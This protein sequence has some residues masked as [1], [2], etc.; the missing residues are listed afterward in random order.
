[1]DFPKSVHTFYYTWYGNPDVDGFWYHWETTVEE[2]Y[3]PPDDITANFYPEFGVYSSNDPL[4]LEEHVRQIQAAGIDVLV[5]TWTG[6]GKFEDNA[7]DALL[8]ACEGK[9]EVAFHYEPQPDRTAAKV[10]DDLVYIHER[11]GA[12]PA[13]YK[14]EGRLFFYVYDSYTTAPEEWQALMSMIRGTPVDSW[15]IGLYVW[16]DGGNYCDSGESSILTSGFDGFYTYF[17]VDGF[18]D[19]S[20]TANWGSLE[21]WAD[22][23]G[24]LFIPCA[25]PGYIDTRV[26][27]WNDI[28][29]RSREGGAYYD[30]VLGAALA[31]NN[32]RVI[33]ITSFNEWHEGTQ[34]ETTVPKSI[35]GYTYE[36]FEPLAPDHYL[37]QT[38]VWADR[39]HDDGS[40][41][42]LSTTA[43][44]GIA[45][46]CTAGVALVGG[47]LTRLVAKRPDAE[48]KRDPLLSEQA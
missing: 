48:Q 37:T 44:V 40:N 26:R 8:A 47:L 12:H 4:I 1:L 43:I 45:V 16:Q 31:L 34:I 13:M 41:S 25:G 38:K 15:M 46:G 28:N 3:A 17:A 2:T 36:D 5:H 29:T 7:T 21:S 32:P 6:I 24:L 22:D 33:G 9:I 27:P 35:E 39:F 30:R 18:T 19:G 42:G 23:N 20:T 10:Y 11:Y 14:P